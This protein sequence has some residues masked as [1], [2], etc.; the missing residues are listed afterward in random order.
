MPCRSYMGRWR[1]RLAFNQPAEGNWIH[2]ELFIDIYFAVD[3]IL[4]FHTAYYD[5]SGGLCGVKVA[6]GG[7]K[8]ASTADLSALYLNYAKGWMAI[9]VAS[10]LPVNFIV[11]LMGDD[12]K[13]DTGGQLKMLKILRLFRLM[14][15]LRLAR[16][17]RICE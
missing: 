17:M 10:V 1:R 2:F 5:D 12:N 9:D 16:A 14:K 4:N 15:L 6:T 3:V 8:Q 11:S 13:A 7:Q